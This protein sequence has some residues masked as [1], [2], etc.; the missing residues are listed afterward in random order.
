M[1]K[2]FDFL[3]QKLHLKD[4]KDLQNLLANFKEIFVKNESEN[5]KINSQNS[6]N[7]YNQNDKCT[8]NKTQEN[9][10]KLALFEGFEKG[11]LGYDFLENKLFLKPEFFLEN[12]AHF[13]KIP[14]AKLDKNPQ[15][16]HNFSRKIPLKWLKSYQAL[17]FKEDEKH[18]FI[19]FSKPFSS[20]IIDKLSIF[21]RPKAIKCAFA[22]PKSINALLKELEF[23]QNIQEII[24][25]L[26]VELESSND[27]S[28][29]SAVSRLFELII[30]QSIIQKSSDIHI[31]PTPTNALIRFRQDGIL[32]VFIEL[33]MQIYRA[34]VSYIKLLAHLNVAEQRKAQDGSFTMCVK[35][36]KY[37]F[38]LSTLP[39]L[40]GESVVLR[41][42]EHKSDFMSLDSLCLNDGDLRELKRRIALPY[43]LILLTGPTGSGKST[44][45]Y[46]ALNEI[47]SVEKKIITAED[48]IEYR[49][50]LIS[51]IALNEKAGLDFANA[52]RTI[53]R[54]D[55]DV[56]VIGEIRDEESLD[57]AIKSSLTGHLVFSTL[58]TNDAVSAVVRMLDMG[59]KPYLIA[60]ALSLIIAQRLVRKLCEHCK[61]KVFKEIEGIS[62]EFYEAKGCERCKMSGYSGREAV[63]EFLFVDETMAF[64]IRDG[65]KSDE[66][67]AYARKNGFE[68]MF[69]RGLQKA[70][71]G[72][73][74]L[75]ELF[76]VMR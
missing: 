47:K 59:A 76:R 53:L 5:H 10:L 51:Q 33:E 41:I 38:R 45:L 66:I 54:Q 43:G 73:T 14:F 28:S 72:K 65:A 17:P 32:S 69:E 35:S 37:D 67:V 26:K 27:K 11:I 6:V 7:F 48:P 61:V 22:D 60:A 71:D 50:P 34:L 24:L 20:Q 30:T 31:E 18:L 23:T 44:T 1:T 75:E 52:L 12:Y 49:L 2:I 63:C 25:G 4:E 70:K 64:M 56:I 55:P 15:N 19:A 29:E 58:H 36:Q 21:V 39:L 13:K 40:Y 62:G 42:L 46:S 9:A 3:S 68:T 16:S 8:T 74:S 57:I